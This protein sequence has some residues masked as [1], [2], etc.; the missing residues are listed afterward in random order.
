MRKTILVLLMVL[1]NLIN[2]QQK[3]DTTKENKKD[4]PFYIETCIDKMTDKSYAFG[5]KSLLCSEDGKK[6]FIVRITLNNKDGEVSYNGLNVKSVGIGSCVE[7]STLIILFEDDTKVQVGAWNKFNCEGNNYMDW[8]GK[9]FDKITEKKVKAL[10]FQNGRTMDSYTYNV[11]EKE[12]AFFLEVASA[13]SEKRIVA[14]SCD[15]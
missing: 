15:D 10:R 12:R 11:P 3:S 6:G 1:P 7:N 4:I 2:A 14:G 8:Q 13:L 9:S 5:S